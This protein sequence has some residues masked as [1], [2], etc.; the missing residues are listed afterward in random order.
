MSMTP[1]G[2]SQRAIA[3]LLLVTTMLAGAAQAQRAGFGKVTYRVVNLTDGN[4]YGRVAINASGQVAYSYTP[5]IFEVPVSA[6]F[7]DGVRS[8][9]IGRLGNDYA[10]VTGLNNAGQV[11]GQSLNA[12]GKDRSFI[13]SPQRPMADIGILPGA[14]VAWQPA[15]NNR[16]VV[17]GTMSA[18]DGNHAYR[19]SQSTGLTDL[20]ALTPA[21]PRG[22]YPS[23]LN[24]AGT[25]VGD[26]RVDAIE[27]HAFRWTFGSGMVD[28]HTIGATDSMAAGIDAGGTIAGNYYDQAAGDGIWRAYVWTP[29][30]GM[31]PLTY[32]ADDVH[33]SGITASGRVIGDLSRARDSYRAF[34]WTRPGGIVELGTLGGLGSMPYGANN[35][36]QVVGSAA[37]AS[38]RYRPFVW[39]A[40]EGMTDLSR[41]LR[42]APPGL[43][44]YEAVA[45]S[46]NGA[47]VALSNTGLVLLKPATG[48]PCTCPHTVGP[49]TGRSLLLP[50]ESFDVAVG[51]AGDNPAAR[52]QVTWSWG[53]GAT[54]SAAAAAQPG[55]SAV[56]TGAGSAV[57][58]SSTR[59]TY[60]APGVYTVSATVTDDSGASVK[61]SRKIV[62]HAAQGLAGAG[63][64]TS[65]AAAGRKAQGRSDGASF[66]FV[67]PST[68]DARNG[69]GSAGGALDFHVGDLHFRSTDI[70]TVALANGRGQFA[71][72]G[73]M[74]GSDGYRFELVAT[75][76]A[77]NAPGHFGL[78]IW[79][80][81][82]LTGA[83]VIDY[84][85]GP[86]GAGNRGNAVGSALSEGSI[87]LQ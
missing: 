32:G 36:G 81:D 79:H 41:R 13:W 87:V 6:F 20:G 47:I 25:I 70:V 80:V 30:G 1:H 15:I 77:A 76:S 59:H 55:A 34:T 85:N 23:A 12:A 82:A 38:G 24:D 5:D 44:L 48:S 3:A 2:V 84:D 53:D 29:G 9:N 11:V 40:R 64:F 4:P 8:R 27:A 71:G 69:A 31:R 54:A 19:W 65:P 39:S 33:I 21:L 62:V 57:A 75:A 7:Y 60:A 68:R 63:T 73:S 61:V 45:V 22:V 14:D 72:S 42:H 26:A 52:Y 43:E 49:I 51:I 16:G 37:D 50:G 17:A 18:P 28:I 58:R 67:A 10:L 78:R 86:S 74:N 56:G 35:V 66:A 83:Q 46:D